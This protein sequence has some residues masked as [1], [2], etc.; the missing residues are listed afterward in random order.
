[1]SSRFTIKQRKKPSNGWREEQLQNAREITGQDFDASEITP[2]QF[3]E[4]LKQHHL[5]Q[6][7]STFNND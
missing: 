5:D 4:E 7:S 3:I 2:E 6:I 1:M